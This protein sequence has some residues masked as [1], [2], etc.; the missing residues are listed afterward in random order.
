L[1]RASAPYGSLVI[2]P[3]HWR[4]SELAQRRQFRKER[5]PVAVVFG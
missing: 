3:G 2:W 5:W 1:R 4:T